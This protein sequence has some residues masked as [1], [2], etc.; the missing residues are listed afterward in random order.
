[1]A[2][3]EHPATA[4]D[5]FDAMANETFESPHAVYRRL[6]AECPVAFSSAHG[7]FWALTRYDDVKAA[8]SDPATYISSVRAVVPSDPRGTRRPPLN[9]DAP[10]HTPYRRA[11]DRTLSKRRLDAMASRLREH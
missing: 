9:F 11:I 7:G 3:D 1:M 10:L 2:V 5:D 6:R 4:A 8:A